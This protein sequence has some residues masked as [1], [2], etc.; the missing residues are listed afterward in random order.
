VT[1]KDGNDEG[2]QYLLRKTIPLETPIIPLE[3]KSAH[4]HS[5]YILR[6]KWS[7]SQKHWNCNQSTLGWGMVFVLGA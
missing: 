5:V 2:L 3:T 4:I 6:S 1:K 7:P